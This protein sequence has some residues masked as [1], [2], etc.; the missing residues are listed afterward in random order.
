MSDLFGYSENNYL[1]EEV[2]KTSSSESNNFS[3]SSDLIVDSVEQG[4][5]TPNNLSGISDIP[6][7][8]GGL[9]STGHAREDA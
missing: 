6:T 4:E 7:L 8:R 2:D 9:A 5:S 1:Y 3:S